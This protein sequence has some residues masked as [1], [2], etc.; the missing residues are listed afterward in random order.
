MEPVSVI[1]SRSWAKRLIGHQPTNQKSLISLRSFKLPPA[2]RS[3][4]R[5]QRFRLC[6]R[7]ASLT[8]T[9]SSL[10]ASIS[11]NSFVHWIVQCAGLNRKQT[12]FAG[13]KCALASTIWFLHASLFWTCLWHRKGY[14]LQTITADQ[15]LAATNHLCTHQE[16]DANGEQCTN[17]S[18]PHM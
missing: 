5:V 13:C 6:F 2:L 11:T 7:L 10:Q 15:A 4:S 14:D 17:R 9:L 16:R 12:T 3:A 8:G 18:I 1:I